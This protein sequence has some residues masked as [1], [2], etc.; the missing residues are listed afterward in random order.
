MLEEWRAVIVD[1]AAM[2]LINGNEVQKDDF[3]KNIDEPGCFLTKGCLNKFVVKLD[4][5]LRTKTKYFEDVGYPISF[6]SAIAMQIEKLA[7]A[8]ENEDATIYSSLRIR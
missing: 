1:S 4:E 2:S 7:S 8:I 5:K 6:R 3:V